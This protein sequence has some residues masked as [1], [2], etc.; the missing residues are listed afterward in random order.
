MVENIWSQVN[1]I[2]IFNFSG[3]MTPIYMRQVSV[4]IIGWAEVKAT[5]V[6]VFV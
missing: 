4:N 5:N 6:Q 3:E 2:Y 1:I